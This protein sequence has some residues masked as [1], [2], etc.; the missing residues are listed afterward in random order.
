MA[1]PTLGQGHPFRNQARE[2][3]SCL[4]IG[5]YY[6]N[7]TGISVDGSD[8][9]FPSGILEKAIDD[10]GKAMEF[11]IDLGSTHTMLS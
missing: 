7:L 11:V 2:H 10:D 6:L 9:D 1:W 4:M 3:P 8:L 5:L